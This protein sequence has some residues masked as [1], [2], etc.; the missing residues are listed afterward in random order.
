[1]KISLGPIP[2]HWEPARIKQFYRE[3]ADLPLDIVYLGETVCSKRRPLHWDAWCQIAEQ[4]TAAGKETVFSTL[5]LSEAESELAAL[6]R[7]TGNGYWRVEANDMAAVYLLAHSSF[8][9]GPHINIYNDRALAFLHGLGG[10]RWVVPVEIGQHQLEHILRQRPAGMQTEVIAFGRLPLAFSARCFSARAHDRGKDECDFICGDYPDGLSLNTRNG[11]PFLHI[12]GIQIQSA[13]THN[14]IA[15]LEELQGI[16]VDI[17][18][19]LPQLNGIREII[20]AFR[21]VLDGTI[22]PQQGMQ[23]L[24]LFQTTGFSDGYWRQQ[25]GMDWR[26]IKGPENLR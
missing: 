16:G 2:Y 5:A 11:D 18:R 17:I 25:A 23:Q 7:I 20:P 13:R 8:V 15:H 19:V 4:L 10:S 26:E 22:T 21:H 6:G 1:M 24:A 3:V 12:N 9:I 14:L